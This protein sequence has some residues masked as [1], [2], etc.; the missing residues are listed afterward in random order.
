VNCSVARGGS[1][2]GG[3]RNEVYIIE[4]CYFEGD[5]HVRDRDAGAGT[6]GA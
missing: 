2:I 6:P 1:S 3:I 4:H 5:E